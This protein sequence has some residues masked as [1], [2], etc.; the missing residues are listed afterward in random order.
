VPGCNITQVGIAAHR[1]HRID[2]DG[3][4]AKLGKLFDFSAARM[5]GCRAGKIPVGGPVRPLGREQVMLIGDAAGL[6]SPLTAGGIHTAI[7][8]GRQA[9]LAICDHLLDGG[10][11]PCRG[12]MQ[13]LPRFHF[14]RLMRGA[15]DLN[16][17]N[18][19]YDAMIGSPLFAH[20]ARTVFFHHRGLLSTQAWHD[21]LLGWR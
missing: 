7:D 8:L 5:V 20:V 3:F 16:P 11:D 13:K 14:K 18:W 6:V 9:G 12:M 4:V 10:M 19:L 2:L 1:G 21:L 15:F 17:P